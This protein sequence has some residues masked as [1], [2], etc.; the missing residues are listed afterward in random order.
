M[1]E[2]SASLAEALMAKH[3]EGSEQQQE[4][5]KKQEQKPNGSGSRKFDIKSFDAFPTLGNASSN[6]PKQTAATGS[7]AWGSSSPSPRPSTA[8]STNNSVASTIAARSN[9]VSEV[10]TLQRGQQNPDARKNLAEAISKARA[11]SGA[12]VESSTSKATGNISFVLKGRQE[13]VQQ[14]RRELHKELALRLVKKVPVPASVR[15]AIIGPKGS[16]LKPIQ[17]K[18]GTDIQ[19]ARDDPNENYDNDDD[20]G[21]RTVDITITGDEEGI[22]VATKEIMDIIAERIKEMTTKLSSISQKYYPFI[23]G[24]NQ[25]QLNAFTQG[26][27]IKVTVPQGEEGGPIAIS[28]ERNAVLE[29]KTAIEHFVKN[30]I[31]TYNTDTQAI[32]KVKHKFLS[33]KEV[34]DATSTAVYFP[35]AS[36][37]SEVVELFGHP[38]KLKEAKAALTKQANS[39]SVLSLDISKAHGKCIPHARN[40]AVF[41][42]QCDKL[43]SLEKQHNVKISVPALEKLYVSDLADVTLE[44]VG[45]NPDEIKEAKKG[46]VAMVNAYGPAYVR[47]VDDLD[48]FFFPHVVKLAKNIKQQHFVDVLV[49]ENSRITNHVVLVYEG[50]PNQDDEDFAPGESEIRQN[51]DTVNK[52]FD[53]IRSKQQSIVSKVLND[54]PRDQHKYITGPKNTTLNSILHRIEPDPLVSVVFG[55]V[56]SNTLGHDESLSLTQDSVWIRG[57]KSEVD[58]VADEIAIAVAA[59][60]EHEKASAYS[61]ECKFPKEHVN[62]LIGKQGANLTKLREEFGVKIDV[63]EEGK[64]T[65]KGIKVNAD[66]A[67]DR[68]EQ[69]AKKALDETTIRLKIPNEYHANLIG[70]SGK[71]VRRLEEKYDVR[72]RFPREQ[73]YSN[74][75][76]RDVPHHKDEIVVRGPSKGAHRAKEELEDL[77]K[78]EV[79]HNY[80]ETIKV[81]TK[82]LPRIIGRQGEYINEIK[83]NTDT[84]IDVQQDQQQ[85]QQ[86]EN[87][88]I[89]IVGTK[90]GVKS[91]VE[92]IQAISK[93]I[94]ET[95]TEEV[96]VDPKY[97]RWLIGPGGSV[98]REMILK[99]C[100]LKSDEHQDFNPR[101]INIPKAGTNDPI[102]KVTGNKKVVNRIVKAIKEIVSEKERQVEETVNVPTDKHRSLIGPG[103]IIKRELEEE[104]NV[105]IQIPRQGSGDDK[106]IVS[107]MPE[108]V[109]KAKEKIAALTANPYKAEIAVPKLLHADL[110]DRGTF[111][112]K[113]KNDFDV[114]VEHGR[115]NL[116]KPA[117]I[118]IPEEAIGSVLITDDE[119]DTASK[120]KWTVVKDEAIGHPQS[121]ATIPWKLRGEDDACQRAKALIESTLD[122]VSKHNSTGYMWLADPTRYR[123]LIGPGGSRINKIRSE[124]G[125]TIAVPKAG[126]NSNE[127]VTLRGNDEQL[128]KARQM[129][130]ASIQK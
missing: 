113:L 6:G 45:S 130:L 108:D 68:I 129:I 33:A 103:G 7:G 1:T 14:A 61:T 30:I 19:V 5:K 60:K 41:F 92:L 79:E 100:G 111:I 17:E 12:S 34:F 110:A 39:L 15:G 75:T 52:M 90:S 114:R 66:A 9:V 82:A 27:D 16:T 118:K 32:P 42:K 21:E 37:P 102:I 70:Q 97:H 18:S 77:Y 81:P 115:V 121:E 86:Q 101:M 89:V 65:I 107:G 40:L 53:D 93:E 8:S 55:T 96:S 104:H 80:T 51:L 20:N 126:A 46:L 117:D 50:N 54:Y 98:M 116:P 109:E 106:V 10:F 56:E 125:C 94:E 99:A 11:N 72:I 105:S 31:N 57:V 64:V 62:K 49:P 85:Q 91:A 43:K 122:Q 29:T 87:T 73:G 35:D 44:I 128:E 120:W 74:E 25:A 76:N 26:K 112:R 67:K 119:K 69:Q 24:P 88:E 58:R 47:E 28:G 84:K 13:A 63:D 48:P 38:S 59:S 23:I 123:L 3:E 124:S 71:F 2:E 78:W 83:D 127:V 36:D 4:S 95:V 22:R